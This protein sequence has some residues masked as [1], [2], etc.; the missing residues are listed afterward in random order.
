VRLRSLEVA[1]ERLPPELDGLRIVHLSDF[2]LGL[3]SRGAVAVERAVEWTAERAPDLV[4][5]SGDLLSRGSGESRLRELLERLP[6]PAFAILGNHDFAISRDPFS[7]RTALVELGHVGLLSDEGQTI[8]LR[9]KRIYVAGSDPRA[10]WSRKRKRPS[11]LAVDD[12]DLS[13]LLCHYP[14]A[15]DGLPP[16]AFDLVLAG[17]MHDGQ[18]SIPLPGTKLRLAHPTARYTSGLYR[19]PGGVLHVSPGLGTTFV[20]FRFFARP[21]ATELTLRRLDA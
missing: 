15:I 8:E 13:I 18:I 17:H 11:E 3:P 1:I 19:R 2:H 6:G 21:E 7:E 4:C 20:P 9:G 10:R 16:G 12:A 5:L 14:Q